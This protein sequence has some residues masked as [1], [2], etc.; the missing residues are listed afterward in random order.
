MP[1]PSLA[2]ARIDLLA[3]DRED[4]LQLLDDEVGLADWAGRS[5]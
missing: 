4:V 2:D 3:R 1:V 5:C